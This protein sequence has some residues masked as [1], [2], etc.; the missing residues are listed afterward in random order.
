MKTAALTSMLVA[1]GPRGAS[2]PPPSERASAT[3]D[4]ATA[5]APTT[6]PTCNPLG[7]VAGTQAPPA[8]VQ[9]D[10]RDAA[11]A[12]AAADGWRL[13]PSVTFTVEP[14]QVAGGRATLRGV[15]ANGGAAPAEVFLVEAGSLYFYATLVGDGLVRRPQPAPAA[16]APPP[17]PPLFPEPHGYTLPP[18]ARWPFEV[19]LELGCWALTPGQAVTAHWWLATAGDGVAGRA[20]AHRAVAPI[21]RPAIMRR[22]PPRRGRGPDTRAPRRARDHRR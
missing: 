8:E 14:A 19:Q 10:G 4:A 17:P 2:T 22:A 20:V 5:A 21:A 13:P 7:F 16:D 15:L 1:C 3:T 12:R 11:A 9:A 18:G 6:A